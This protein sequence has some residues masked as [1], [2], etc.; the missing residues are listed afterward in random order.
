SRRRASTARACRAARRS[1][2]EALE[3]VSPGPPN[4]LD[5]VIDTMRGQLAPQTRDVDLDQVG[6]AGEVVVPDVVFDLS[7]CEHPVGMVEEVLE[8]GELLGGE[9]DFLSID[10]DPA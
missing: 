6:L 1:A 10:S 3:S 9:V 5:E 2:G 4:G 8:D 7:S